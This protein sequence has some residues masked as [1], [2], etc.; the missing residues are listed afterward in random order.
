[1]N[2]IDLKDKICLEA[3]RGIQIHPGT[4]KAGSYAVYPCC[5]AWCNTYK[6]GDDNVNVASIIEITNSEAARAFR[7]SILN[8][9][10]TYCNKKICPLIS[11]NKLVDK[12]DVLNGKYGNY[13]ADIV[14]SNAEN[15]EIQ[16]MH[17]CYDFSCNFKCP[18]C[19][20]T[21]FNITKNNSGDVYNS[22]MKLQEE[23]INFV[24]RK[25]FKFELGLSGSGDPIASE[26]GRNLLYSLDKSKNDKLTV[27]IQT[28]GSLF[29]ET[30][31]NNMY[32]MHGNIKVIVS[33]DAGTE[34]TYSKIRVN[35][36]WN[37]LMHNLQMISKLYS[38]NLI[39]LVRLD[40]V[41]QQK[42]YM[43]IPL[44]I[45]IAKN[46][47]VHC[48]ISRLVNWGTFSDDEF[49]HENIFDINHPEHNNFLKILNNNYDYDKIEWGNVVEFKN[50]YK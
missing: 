3:I 14:K 33:I 6:Y 34:D 13:C 46:L 39:Q 35:G 45:N 41:C 30:F 22:Y 27:L 9:E 31:W 4:H 20:K 11:G 36:N 50:K 23:I 29:N 10:Y 44:F 18:S 24:H 5:P 2:N 21:V 1:M 26:L 37:V 17:L 15:V 38:S 47:N 19:R 28:N 8:G 49:K 32:K 25:S 42:N 12:T 7:A 43:E 48:T 40:F 16:N